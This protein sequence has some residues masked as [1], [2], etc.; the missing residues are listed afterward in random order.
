MD[1]V[2][3]TKLEVALAKM[4]RRADRAFR[5]DIRALLAA[6]T[7]EEGERLARLIRARADAHEEYMR[8]FRP[9][10]PQGN[11]VPGVPLGFQ[12]Q[13]YTELLDRCDRW[14]EML[15]ANRTARPARPRFQPDTQSELDP[16]YVD[17]RP[18]DFGDSTQEL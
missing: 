5:R 15:V 14:M 3:D 13:M 11:V 9:V 16:L 18:A 10:T 7:D 8:G 6:A 1:P 17:A 4:A 2:P 12:G